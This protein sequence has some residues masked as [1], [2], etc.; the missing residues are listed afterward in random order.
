MA[1]VLIFVFVF[2]LS[3]GS[4]L[5]VVGLRIPN[6]ES[7]V[8]PGSMCPTCHYHLKPYDLVPVF[9]YL[10]L[11]GKCRKCKAGIS[12]KYPAMEFL[13]GV[14]FVLIYL[15]AT[16]LTEFIFQLLL[17]SVMIALTVSDL[18]YRLVPNKIL[19]YTFIILVPFGIYVNVFIGEHTILEHILGGLVFFFGLLLVSVIT[20]GG[21]GGGDIKLLGLLGFTLGIKETFILFMIA[22]F[23]G[24]IIG[25]IIKLF[26]KTKVLPFVP[27]ICVGVLVTFLYSEEIWRFLLNQ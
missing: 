7:I 18:E 21:M 11:G 12:V 22:C 25:I 5:N 6:K 14:S 4:F 26:K 24:A 23:V 13:T 10:F 16:S 3:I 15:F 2:G 27:F 20:K 9:S 19:I 17:L 1:I 8:S